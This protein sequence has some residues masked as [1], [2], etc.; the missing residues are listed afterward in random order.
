MGVIERVECLSR[1]IK[2]NN[3]HRD[4]FLNTLC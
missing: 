2:I 3:S 4:I 1:F